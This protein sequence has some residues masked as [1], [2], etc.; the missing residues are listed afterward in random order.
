M[1]VFTSGM[2]NSDVRGKT[3]SEIRSGGEVGVGLSLSVESEKCT[4][5][6]GRIVTTLHSRRG[7]RAGTQ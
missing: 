3:Q 1:V 2:F 7:D 5:G 6:Q 4:V